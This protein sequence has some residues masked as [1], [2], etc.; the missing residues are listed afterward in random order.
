MTA[1]QPGYAFASEAQS[2]WLLL[3][4]AVFL[5]AQTLLV[6]SGGWHGGF[7]TINGAGRLL[8]DTL[9]ESLTQIG[10]TLFALSLFLFIA[11][12]HPALLWHAVTAAIVATLLSHGLKALAAQ[13]RPAAV[14]DLADFRQL[15]P[16]LRRSSFPSGHTVTAFVSAACVACYLPALWQRALLLLAALLVGFSRVAVGAHWPIDVCGGAAVGTLA[17]YLGLLLARRWP[18]GL[19]PRVHLL[20]VLILAG[21][22]LA[23]LLQ[24]PDYLLARPLVIVVSLLALTVAARDYLFKPSR[25][26]DS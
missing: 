22:T 9:A 11:K 1:P 23:Q 2:R 17:A 21:C 7:M 26:R 19:R 10:D 25:T 14:L 6:A 5:I 13:P 24:K 15:G 18:W 12:R 20:L 8:N 3:L 4:F 16:V